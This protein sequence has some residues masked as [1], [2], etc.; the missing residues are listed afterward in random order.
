MSETI[1]DLLSIDPDSITTVIDNGVEFQGNLICHSGKAIMI[2]GKFSG[3]IESEG[4]IL[5]NEGAVVS[6]SIKANKIKLAGKITKSEDKAIPSEVY[7]GEAI[8]LAKTGQLTTDTLTY[9]GLEMEFGA[10]I[11]SSRMEP[12]ESTAPVQASR[13]A[14]APA[15]FTP[16]V[17]RSTS[18]PMPVSME[19]DEEDSSTAA[20]A[21][22]SAP[23]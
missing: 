19:D 5:I 9:G 15:S 8:I 14:P 2:S 13:P 12:L 11:V 20:A 16:S 1:E 6:G 4:S 7:A 21:Y 22:R 3:S 10:R 23:N 17:V 18:M